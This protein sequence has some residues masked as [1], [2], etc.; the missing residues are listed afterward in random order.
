MENSVTVILSKKGLLVNP[1]SNPEFGFIQLKQSAMSVDA[2]GWVRPVN[3]YALLKG[4]V[5]DLNAL[6]YSAGKTL[7]GT[8]QVV[9][10][11]EPTNSENLEQDKKIAGDTGIACTLAG[12][13]IYRTSVYKMDADAIDVLIAHDNSDAIK[14]AQEALASADTAGLED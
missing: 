4:S 6:S 12:R 2:N 5:A 11:H 1:S 10:S 14:S 9:E 7:A 3:K 8:I 13:P